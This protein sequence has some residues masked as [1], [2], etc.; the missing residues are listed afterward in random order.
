M[1]KKINKLDTPSVPEEIPVI[2]TDVPVET[3]QVNVPSAKSFP[4]GNT[5]GKF[6]SVPFN[7]G[8]VV[9][10]PDGQRITG[11]VTKVEADDLVRQNNQ[12]AH[13]KG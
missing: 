11:I 10:N 8:H 1:R 7:N 9:Y 2:P 12:A 5:T 6:H 13:I 4:E 3:E